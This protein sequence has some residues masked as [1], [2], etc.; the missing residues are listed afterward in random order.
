MVRFRECWV[1]AP[2]QGSPLWLPEPSLLQVP[3]ISDQGPLVWMT[4]RKWGHTGL[5]AL[6][7]NKAEVIQAGLKGELGTC[8]AFQRVPNWQGHK[9]SLGG[10]RARNTPRAP[11][12]AGKEVLG[13]EG[14]QR[15][16]G[17]EWPR[18]LAPFHT[19]SN[20]GQ[21]GSPT[22]PSPDPNPQTAR[23]RFWEACSP[24]GPSCPLLPE[25]AMGFGPP[26]S[27]LEIL[28]GKVGHHLYPWVV[29]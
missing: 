4:L 24:K 26:P 22:G 3:D 16:A 11:G 12:G 14:L 19:S 1:R 10:S 28:S 5:L 21:A 27:G 6:P 7:S 15:H 18:A 20:P 13:K 25:A 29:S 8:S 2:T 9:D 23:Q 17:S